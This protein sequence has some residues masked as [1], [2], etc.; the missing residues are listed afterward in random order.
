MRPTAWTILVEPPLEG[1]G[2]STALIC[3][4]CL[5]MREEGHLG[6]EHV[7]PDDVELPPEVAGSAYDRAP[8]RRGGF[9]VRT[10]PQED[11]AAPSPQSWPSQVFAGKRTPIQ[12]QGSA[13]APV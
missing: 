3:F 5:L 13:T 7:L 11:D 9:R 10:A 6:D 2:D 1:N 8:T 4:L 12:D